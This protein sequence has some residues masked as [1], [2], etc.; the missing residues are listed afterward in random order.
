[1]EPIKKITVAFVDTSDGNAALA[2]AAQLAARL[3]AEIDLL[4]VLPDTFGQL[5]ALKDLYLEQ[6]QLVSLPESISGLVSLETLSL[7]GNLLTTLPQA[8]FELP[9]LRAVWM[10]D[11]QLETIPQARPLLKAIEARRNPPPPVD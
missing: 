7:R 4:S 5:G 6:N 1:M 2:T 11:R 8:L 10:D 9:S 3:G